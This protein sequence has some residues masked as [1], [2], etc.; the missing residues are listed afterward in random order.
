MRPLHEGGLRL[1]R[2]A[3]CVLERRDVEPARAAPTMASGFRTPG[4][5][6]RVPGSGLRAQAS[7]FRV[8]GSG[9]RVLA[10]GSSGGT[11][12]SGMSAGA[13][14]WPHPCR[15]TAALLPYYCRTTAV[16]LPYCALWPHPR[17]RAL[18]KKNKKQ[19][20][21]AAQVRR[22]D[23][24]QNMLVAC[25]HRR[26]EVRAPHAAA[27]WGR[28]RVARSDSTGRSAWPALRISQ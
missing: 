17:L 14:L 2:H 23:V 4:S 15:T 18:T 19:K 12:S 21:A 16:L 25:S 11:G 26:H 22:P 13:T 5:G 3:H 7:R 9:F 1:Q 20:E 8:P 24:Q 27:A 6:F 10:S 28:Q